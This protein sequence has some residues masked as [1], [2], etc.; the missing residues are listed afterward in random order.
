MIQNALSSRPLYPEYAE[1]MGI[2][3]NEKTRAARLGPEAR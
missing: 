1:P 3:R 2:G